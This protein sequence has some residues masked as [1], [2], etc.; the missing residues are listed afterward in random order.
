MKRG[1]LCLFLI[2][3]LLLT[4]CGNKTA[5]PPA[6]TP[7]EV[8]PEMP[9]ETLPEASPDAGTPETP[10]TLDA[11]LADIEAAVPGTAGSSLRAAFAAGEFLD[12][13][14]QPDRE[15]GE[16]V[17]EW[18]GKH[19]PVEN[20]LDLALAWNEVLTQAD[21]LLRGDEMAQ[22]CL[23]DAGYILRRESYDA[24]SVKQAA[25]MLSP[26]FTQLLDFTL[27]TPR[28]PEAPGDYSAVTEAAF[29]GVWINNDAQ[30]LLLFS[31]DTCRV[32]YPALDWYGEA[33]Y[34]FRVRDRSSMGYCP[35]L[36]IDF[37]E[38]G[39]FTAPLAY[40]V[41]GIDE[42]HFWSSTTGES[43]QKLA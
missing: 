27:P 36:E 9:S 7:P 41:S 14:Q 20:T 31:G 32:V 40:Y 18:L 26:I 5:A 39:D 28:S 15:T 3:M 19:V 38:S 11:L 6:E 35:A 33:A 37:R 21:A 17:R 42:T 22:G 30:T 29:A 16:A 1:V 8:V 10:L 23:S 43:F 24:D 34:A 4:G 25:R 12:W 13:S 2:L